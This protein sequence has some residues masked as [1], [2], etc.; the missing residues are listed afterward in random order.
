MWHIV[1]K[2]RERERKKTIKLNLMEKCFQLISG[3]VQMAYETRYRPSIFAQTVPG[4][5]RCTLSL[6]GFSGDRIRVRIILVGKM[7]IQFSIDVVFGVV[8]VAS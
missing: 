4:A 5:T 1:R 3:D 8:V 6:I 2:E 7:Q